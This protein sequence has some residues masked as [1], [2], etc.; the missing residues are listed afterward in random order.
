MK[1]V[2]ILQHSYEID[3]YDETKFIGVYSTKKEAEEAINRLKNKA[4]FYDRQDAFHIDK[5]ELNK[6]H[7]T[8]GFETMTTIQVKNKFNEWITV[9]AKYLSNKNYQIIELYDNELLGP[10]KHLDIVECEVRD[11]DYYATKLA[12]VN[13][14]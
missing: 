10:F 3:G 2:F 4:G 8:E 7:W 5:Y 12:S 9:Q 1:S 11:R 14:S 13:N 6:D